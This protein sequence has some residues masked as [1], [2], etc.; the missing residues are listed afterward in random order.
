MPEGPEIKHSTKILNERLNSYY[1]TKFE[2]IGNYINRDLLNLKNMKKDLPLQIKEIFSRGKRINFLCENSKKEGSVF[3]WFYSMTGRLCFEH[4]GK[5]LIAITLNKDL[6]MN[7]DDEIILY[8][9]DSRTLGWVKYAIADEEIDEIYKDVGPDF[10]RDE[11]SLEYFTSIIRNK[12]IRSKEIGE[13]L[14]VQRYFSSIGNY[15]RAEILYMCK[16]SP[17]RTLENLTDRDIKM[18]YDKTIKILK[19]STQKGGMSFRDYINPDGEKGNFECKVYGQDTDP[20]GNEVV[21]EKIGTP[22]KNG[23]DSRRN[24]WWVPKLQK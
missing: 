11:V 9:E 16:I 14:I 20:L 8:Y 4:R 5:P 2:Y 15:L 24:I 18:L 22:P 12:R 19:E 23:K 6:D 1:I 21:G 13:L 10:L 3:I 7:E 17:F